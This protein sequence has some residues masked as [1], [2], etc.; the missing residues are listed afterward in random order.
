[1]LERPLLIGCRASVYPF[2]L[3][4]LTVFQQLCHG[5]CV[6]SS[7]LEIPGGVSAVLLYPDSDILL[8]PAR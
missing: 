4:R 2:E 5:V 3:I 8:G 1:M 6:L 7:R